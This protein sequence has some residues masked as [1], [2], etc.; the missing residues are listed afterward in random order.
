MRIL[1]DCT[2]T[3]PYFT[4]NFIIRFFFFFF[5]LYSLSMYHGT[6][7]MWPYLYRVLVGDRNTMG[8]R[9]GRFLDVSNVGDVSGR[10]LFPFNFRVFT[11]SNST[12][13]H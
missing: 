13:G 4:M 8:T 2:A 3:T 6:P 1:N 12:T 11:H 10:S 7:F 5:L 9:R